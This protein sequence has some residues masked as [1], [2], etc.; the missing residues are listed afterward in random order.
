MSQPFHVTLKN[1][2]EQNQ[3]TQVEVAERL[4][5][6]RQ[7]YLDLE[8]GKTTIRIDRLVQLSE[9]MRVSVESWFEDT[10]KYTD[11]LARYSDHEL[12]TELG[13]R[14]RKGRELSRLSAS[15][16]QQAA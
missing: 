1:L 11:S 12:L 2:R 5:V 16:V 15:S 13:Q 9:I 4:G 14:M 3:L 8:T 7:T 6:A 10:K